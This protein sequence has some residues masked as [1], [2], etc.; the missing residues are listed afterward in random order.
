MQFEDDAIGG[1]NTGVPERDVG[2]RP[3]GSTKLD[4]DDATFKQINGLARMQCTK[5]EAAA[6][7]GVHPETLRTFFATHEKA[8]EA[9]EDGIETGKASLRRLQ[10]KNATDGNATMQIW[11]GKQ[12][13]DQTDKSYQE[14]AGKDGVP[15][16]PSVNVTINKS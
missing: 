10:F 12:W 2:G 9:W 7:L 3:L 6:V 14:H 15:L 13:L 4:A 11:L 1:E 8:R 16:I 5:R